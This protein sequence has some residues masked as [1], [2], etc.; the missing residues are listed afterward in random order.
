MQINSSRRSPVVMATLLLLLMAA[1]APVPSKA[2]TLNVMTTTQDLASLVRE[3]GGDRVEVE[4]IARGYQDPHFVQA[5]P[6]FLLKLNRADLV[7]LVGLQLEAGWL[8]PLITRSRNRR[9]YR[10][11]C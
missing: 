2:Q 9:I 4:A 10:P 1:S 5:K 3:V 11:C 6:S 7:V 8:P